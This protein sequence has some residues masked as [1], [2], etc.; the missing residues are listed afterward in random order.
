MSS[1]D[2][3]LSHLDIVIT[4]PKV[5]GEKWQQQLEALGAHTTLV[6]MLEIRPIKDRRSSVGSHKV[7]PL[8]N[9][10]SKIAE[11][12]NKLKSVILRLD[13]FKKVIFVSQ[14]AVSEAS[15]WID[16]YWPQHPVGIQYFAVGSATAKLARELGFQ[17]TSP[18]EAM[19]SEDLLALNDFNNVKDQKILIFRGVG[20]RTLLSEELTI[21]G[22]SVTYG[23]LYTRE[24]PQK[25]LTQLRALK[26]GNTHR[27]TVLSAHSGESVVNLN[28]VIDQLTKENLD[29]TNKSSVNAKALPLLIPGERVA[30]IAKELGFQELIVAKNATDNEMKE[31]LSDWQ[32]R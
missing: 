7:N 20:G 8:I 24:L 31:A 3:S 6:P 30:K 28:K 10:D 4:R 21:R 13:E 9:S 27:K 14:N 25:A 2:K 26:L 18:D 23:E 29:A 17:I 15:L 32:S 1:Q 22:A 5:Q 11:R 16:D 19:N 12:L